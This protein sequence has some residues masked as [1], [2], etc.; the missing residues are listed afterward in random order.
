MQ[1]V[2]STST[3]VPIELLSVISQVWPGQ[4][5]CSLSFQSRFTLEED[6]D[7]ATCLSLW[8]RHVPTVSIIVSMNIIL[9]TWVSRKGCCCC[10]LLQSCPTL[11]DHMD[12]SLPSSSVHGILQAR[13][14]EWV[15]MPSSRGSSWPR[16]RTCVSC[17]LHW[18]AGSL[19][20]ALPG[21][22]QKGLDF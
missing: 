21:K 9:K 7:W 16:D 11:H 3:K 15:A 12:C 10:K 8:N 22:M 17:L 6:S 2:I 5:R 4:N 1:L 19:L 13:I 18:P 14:L 20:L